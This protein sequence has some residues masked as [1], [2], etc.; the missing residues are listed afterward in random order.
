MSSEKKHERE[1][2][3]LKIELK[4]RLPEVLVKDELNN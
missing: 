2:K 3:V 4:I 1:K